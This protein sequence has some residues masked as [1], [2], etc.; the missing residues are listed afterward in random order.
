MQKIAQKLTNSNDNSY[1]RVNPVTEKK[2]TIKIR[3]LDFLL[4]LIGAVIVIGVSY[5]P[6][7]SPSVNFDY[8]QGARVRS[9]QLV[10]NGT[11][12]ITHSESTRIRATCF[13][14]YL[15]R[16]LVRYWDDK[17]TKIKEVVGINDNSVKDDS[18]GK[19]NEYVHFKLETP[20]HGNDWFYVVN[21]H[22]NCGIM[23][24]LFTTKI[25]LPAIPVEETK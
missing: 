25:N 15:T 21:V 24:N 17:H 20:V 9:G 23:P 18:L 2:F 13:G 6:F 4:I 19:Q 16:E 12:L 11:E 8:V 1:T 10:N 5:I 14:T 22:E 7:T 3:K